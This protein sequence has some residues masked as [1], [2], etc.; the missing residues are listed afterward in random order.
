MRAL[1]N[2]ILR[3][4][5]ITGHSGKG[6]V[7][8]GNYVQ[9]LLTFEKRDFEADASRESTFDPS[10]CCLFCLGDVSQIKGDV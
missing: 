3:G 6:Y 5:C 8:N 9:Y 2:P 10:I 1:G 4:L 7:F